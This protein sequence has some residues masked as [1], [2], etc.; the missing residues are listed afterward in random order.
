MSVCSRF[1]KVDPA[2]VSSVQ[3]D[4][5]IPAHITATSTPSVSS[6]FATAYSLGHPNQDL[7]QAYWRSPLRAK[8]SLKT[9]NWNIDRS[10]LALPMY[11]QQ[12]WYLSRNLLSHQHARLLDPLLQPHARAGA[13]RVPKQRDVVYSREY[14]LTC[15]CCR[16]AFAMTVV[17]V[18]AI[19]YYP[20]LLLRS[21]ISFACSAGFILLTL[22]HLFTASIRYAPCKI[23]NHLWIRNISNSKF[24]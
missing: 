21:I 23:T 13:H 18:I 6:P 17:G 10:F 4:P 1:S 9:G 15:W 11:T 14:I 24:T 19:E 22:I 12:G 8:L 7:P 2:I 20:C 5:P 16:Y 3:M